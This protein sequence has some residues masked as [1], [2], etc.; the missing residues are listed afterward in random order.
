[1]DESNLVS[2]NIPADEFL[3][4]GEVVEW[5]VKKGN[6]QEEPEFVIFMGGVGSGK[7]TVRQRDFVDGYVHFDY[8]EIYNAIKDEFGEN[9]PGFSTFVN[10]ACSLVFEESLSK[11]KNI[12][13]EIIGEEYEPVKSLITKMREA[14]YTIN[15]Q[16]ITCDITEAYKRHLLAVQNDPAYFSA[17]YSQEPTLMAINHILDKGLLLFASAK[18]ENGNEV[19]L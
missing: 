1:M 14:G 11:K 3:R 12:V 5:F 2:I 10:L 15:V 4:V 19:T 7:T 18:D 8:G 13:I 16:A 9:H 17:H 6:T